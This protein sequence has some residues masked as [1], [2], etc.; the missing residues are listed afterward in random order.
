[1]NPIIQHI[2]SHIMCIIY[3]YMLFLQTFLKAKSKLCCCLGEPIISFC[4]AW[5]RRKFYEKNVLHICKWPR[6]DVFDT[7]LTYV[8]ISLLITLLIKQG[9]SFLIQKKIKNLKSVTKIRV[10]FGVFFSHRNNIAVQLF[11]TRV[12]YY[13]QCQ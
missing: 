5:F 2:S 10:F 8:P 4:R 11:T 9:R 6:N 13:L 12:Y 1:M 7:S 3:I